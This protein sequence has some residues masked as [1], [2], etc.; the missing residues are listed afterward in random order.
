MERG[1][2]KSDYDVRPK[3]STDE[4]ISILKKRRDTIIKMEPRLIVQKAEYGT[5]EMEATVNDIVQKHLLNMVNEI[6]LSIKKLEV[7]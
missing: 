7:L 4:L 6:N 3:L 5:V 2:Q 1:N